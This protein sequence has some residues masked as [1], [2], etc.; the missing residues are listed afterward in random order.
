MERDVGVWVLSG[1]DIGFRIEIRFA[2]L[3]IRIGI[4]IDS[5][6]D[7][8]QTAPIRIEYRNPN[9]IR[10]LVEGNEVF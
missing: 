1:F 2:I 6:L 4:G 10:R 8:E 3:V 7:L 5:V 9:W